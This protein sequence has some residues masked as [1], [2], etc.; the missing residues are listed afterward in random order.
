MFQ[1][2]GSDILTLGVA[3]EMLVPAALAVRSIGWRID[4]SKSIVGKSATVHH[5]ADGNVLGDWKEREKIA[6]YG[7]GQ[8]R[9]P[10]D[11]ASGGNC[12]ACHQ[13]AKSG[14]AYGTLAPSL[15]NCGKDR[16]FDADGVRLSSR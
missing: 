15:T 2:K 9:S 11:I 13:F 14:F 5:S 4:V 1:E 3:F 8:V 12:Y 7:R 10:P 6:G 16:K